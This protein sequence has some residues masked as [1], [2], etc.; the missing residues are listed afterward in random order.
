VNTEPEGARVKLDGQPVGIT[1]M[2]VA[3]PRKAEGVLT[4]ELAGY[5]TRELDVDKVAHGWIFGNIL[6]GGLIGVMV[7]FIT[8]NQGKYSTD[9]IYI[10]L[11]PDTELFPEEDTR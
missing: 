8:S 5:E 2:T 4:F 10:E 6:I 3:F 7:D 11:M 9:A 1:P